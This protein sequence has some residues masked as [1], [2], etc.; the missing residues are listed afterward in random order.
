VTSYQYEIG[1]LTTTTGTVAVS[2]SSSAVTGTS[3]AFLSEYQAGDYILVADQTRIVQTVTNDTSLAVT[4]AFSSPASGQVPQRVRLTNVE[5]LLAGFPA[6]KGVFQPYTIALPL[7]DGGVRG[8]GWKKAVW[9][10]S[11]V[12]QAQRDTL[13]AYCPGASADVY[14]KTRTVDNAD[15]YAIYSAKM[16]WPGPDPEQRDALRRIDFELTFQALIAWP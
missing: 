9:K 6:P 15:A 11:F 1:L 5:N 13:R 14:I 3:T 10:W 12:T 2:A 4:V 16:L 7:E 8:G